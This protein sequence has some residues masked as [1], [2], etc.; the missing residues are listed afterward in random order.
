MV[1]VGKLEGV[2]YFLLYYISGHCAAAALGP[3]GLGGKA[4]ILQD[5]KLWLYNLHL[6]YY[7]LP[8]EESAELFRIKLNE[9]AVVCLHRFYKQIC[10]EWSPELIYFEAA[11]GLHREA[12]LHSV[13]LDAIKRS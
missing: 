8:V 6:F 12:S 2:G 1:E 4:T 13:G 11:G 9:N 7:P 3:Y 5:L 10:E